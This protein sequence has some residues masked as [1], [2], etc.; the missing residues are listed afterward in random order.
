MQGFEIYVYTFIVLQREFLGL[1]GHLG[2]CFHKRKYHIRDKKH[3]YSL[4]QKRAKSTEH[5]H[6]YNLNMF[7]YELYIGNRILTN[8]EN[9]IIWVTRY[10]GNSVEKYYLYDKSIK[11]SNNVLIFYT[12]CLA[13]WLKYKINVN[14]TNCPV[15]ISR[16]C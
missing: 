6:R 12:F 2:S 4:P 7:F 1:R 11:Q 14:N 10:K 15:L 5:L 8:Y 16:N 13:F 9:Y 3:R